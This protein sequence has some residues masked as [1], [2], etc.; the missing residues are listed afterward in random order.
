MSTQDASLMEAISGA[1][2]DEP[3]PS[4]Q[5]YDAGLR[6]LQDAMR[7][8]ETGIPG[9]NTGRGGVLSA[10]AWR[11]WVG[12]SAIAGSL[13]LVVF[14]SRTSYFGN[15]A[16]EKVYTTGNAQRATIQLAD[17]SDIILAPSSTMRV[18]G[19]NGR[20][21]HLD[22][23]AV[24]NVSQSKKDAFTV[25]AGT[26]TIKV[27]GTTFGVRHYTQDNATRVT[28]AVGKVSTGGV[29]LAAGDRADVTEN[30]ATHITHGID[31]RSDLGWTSGT[32]VLN[33]KAFRDALPELERWFGITVRASQPL[34]DEPIRA[35]LQLDAQKQALDMLA[36]VLRAHVTRAGNVITFISDR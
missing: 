21:I 1:F 33:A 29:V 9:T 23:Q 25:I 32:L 31:I 4:Q 18:A 27:L 12:Y 28:V 6:M 17:G 36:Y 8:E 13:L 22:G 34:L 10:R 24:F 14:S 5:E 16:T 3:I 30:S 26:A 2:N 19:K 11:R 7:Q 35:E 15:A 20:K